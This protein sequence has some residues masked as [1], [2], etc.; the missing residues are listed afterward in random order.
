MTTTSRT[1]R[2]TPLHIL[3]FGLAAVGLVAAGCSSGSD[4]GDS[5]GSA[6]PAADSGAERE[7]ADTGAA[8]AAAAPEQQGSVGNADLVRPKAVVSTGVVSLLSDDASQTRADVLKV[9]DVHRGQVT[10]E[11]TS[12]DSDGEVQRS[13]MVLRVP[14]G[15]FY[16]AVEELEGLAELESSDKS[17]EDVSFE[18]IDAEA[19]IRAQERSLRRVELLLDRAQSIRDIVSIEAELTRRQADLDSLESSRAYLADQTS[20]ATITVHLA[21]EDGPAKKKEPETDESGF[22]A[23]LDGGWS[24]L[25]AFATV[26]ATIVGALLPWLVVVGILGVPTWLLL[27]RTARRRPATPTVP[28]G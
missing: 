11:E 1:A 14:S 3:A 10:D 25:R 27:R 23:G 6:A 5:E 12:T 2:R 16:E 7:F 13:R 18:V 8:D 22:V 26:A 4:S 21:Q 20:M 9:V 24:A 28:E 19:R 15:D 17:S